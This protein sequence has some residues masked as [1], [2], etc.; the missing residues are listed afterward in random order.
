MAIKDALIAELKHESGLTKKM[1]ERVPLENKEWRPHEKSMTVGR[2]ATHIAEIPHWI[3]EIIGRD[4]FN[5]ADRPYNPRTAA[6]SEELMDIFQ[7]NIDNSIAALEK[8]TDEDLNQTWTIK[9]GDHVIMQTPKKVAIRGWAYSH[10]YH[11]RGQ[12]SVY[13]R[14]LDVPVPGMYGPSAD[15][16]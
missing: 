13:L 2:L 10:L 14:L 12:L 4:V 6:S 11:H 15:E 8:A 1:L 9:R 16:R 5:F 7:T 3:S